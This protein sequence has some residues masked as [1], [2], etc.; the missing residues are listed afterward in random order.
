MS[1]SPVSHAKRAIKQ[2]VMEPVR[3]G[4]VG[5]MY[6]AIAR[7]RTRDPYVAL[8]F[9]DGP[10]PR[11]TPAVLEVLA[12]HGALATFFLVGEA[13]KG[14]PEVVERTVSAGHAIGS[15]TLSH[16]S[17]PKLPPGELAREIADGHGTLGSFAGPLFRPPYG[18]Y[19]LK[20]A[21][22]A[23]R[24]GLT[25]VLWNM[26]AD[27]WL[28]QSPDDLVRKLDAAVRP[29]AIVLLHDALATHDDKGLPDRNDLLAALDAM[30]AKYAGVYRFV[31]VPQLVAKGP[32]VKVMA[33]PLSTQRLSPAP[34]RLS[35]A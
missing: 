27:D 6:G 19:G 16:P 26:H 5:P 24:L 18:H 12:K 3:D 25:S 21:K 11:W 2:A 8:T 14:H 30:L 22:V 34:R 10:H 15:H 29:G 35:P 20:V 31:T 9:D 32:A 7:V 4:L 33:E 23:K 13:V 17:L 28:R 1:H